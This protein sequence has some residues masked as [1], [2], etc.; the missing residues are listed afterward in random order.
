M[1][2]FFFF[3]EQDTRPYILYSDC[4]SSFRR[5]TVDETLQELKN[6]NSEVTRIFVEPPEPR[7]DSAEEDEG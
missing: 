7:S 3:E 6:G 4:F 5:L 2:F 1:F